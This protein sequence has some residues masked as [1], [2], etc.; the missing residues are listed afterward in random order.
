MDY[1][2]NVSSTNNSFFGTGFMGEKVSSFEDVKQALFKYAT[3]VHEGKKYWRKE[4]KLTFNL[5]S[6]MEAFKAEGDRQ[7]KENGFV[8]LFTAALAL[9]SDPFRDYTIIYRPGKWIDAQGNTFSW[10]LLKGDEVI[11]FAGKLKDL[12]TQIGIT[13]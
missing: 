2:I 7:C 6:T 4:I 10:I 12:L 1:V 3:Y 5:A 8:N 9:K 13:F 11:P